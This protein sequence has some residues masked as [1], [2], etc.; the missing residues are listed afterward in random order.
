[1]FKNI[2]QGLLKQAQYGHNYSN[3]PLVNICL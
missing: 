3:V 2:Y 1:M